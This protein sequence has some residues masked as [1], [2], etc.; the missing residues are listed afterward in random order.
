VSGPGWL[1]GFFTALMIAVAAYCA[2]RLIRTRRPGQ[3]TDRAADGLHVL[4]GL[5]MAGMLQPQLTLIPGTIWCAV[6]A[7]GAAWF[8]WQASPASRRADRARGAHP[9]AH[10]IECAVMVYM[11]GPVGS[12]P[13]SRGPGMAMPGM[14]PAGTVGNPVLTVLFALFMLGYALHA[15]DQLAALSRARLAMAAA[16]PAAGPAPGAAALPSAALAPRLAACYK[17]AMA[18]TMG[19]MLVTML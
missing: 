15:A 10:A 17:I 3:A 9:V 6:F 13:A 8:A 7:A 12:W 14:A 18:I 19:Y 4:M 1:G 11:L 5:A 2:S 16:V